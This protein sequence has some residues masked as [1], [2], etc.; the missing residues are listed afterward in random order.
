MKYPGYLT[1]EIQYLLGTVSHSEKNLLRYTLLFSPS[2]I[3]I[4]LHLQA[5]SLCLEFAQTQLCLKRDSLIKTL[6]YTQS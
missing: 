2:L 3:F 5:V 1:I 4:L 6:E